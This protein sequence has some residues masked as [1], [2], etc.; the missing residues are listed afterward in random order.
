MKKIFT[1]GHSNHSLDKFYTMLKQYDINVL[2]DVRSVPF[3]KFANQF[4]LDKLKSFLKERGVYYIYMG[5]NLGA[6]WSQKELL[7]D[8]GKVN[9][10]KVKRTKEFQEG[11]LRIKNGVNKGY[12]IALM[13]SEEEALNCHRFVLISPVLTEIGYQVYHIYPEYLLSQN[14]LIKRMINMYKHKLMQKSLFKTVESLES[15]KDIVKKAF[16]L[17]NKDIAYN[18]YTKVGDEEWKYIR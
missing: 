8:D 9:F 18:A 1:I 6:R 5:R 16:I 3:S 13:C 4:N 14:D 17:R 7:F 15:D 12:T 2:V 11:I 10:E